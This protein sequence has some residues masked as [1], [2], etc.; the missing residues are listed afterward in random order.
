M[1]DNVPFVDNPEMIINN[2]MAIIQCCQFTILIKDF[3]GKP[4]GE[5]LLSD[6]IVKKGNK[7]N[8]K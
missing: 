5:N 8:S 4:A 7:Y 2:L 3:H 1:H 6:P